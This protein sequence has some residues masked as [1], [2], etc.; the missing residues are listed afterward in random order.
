MSKV[1]K[2]VLLNNYFCLACTF[3]KLYMFSENMFVFAF[4][5]IAQNLIFK[6]NNSDDGRK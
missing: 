4:L 2:T 5:Q 1:L 3:S 6:K